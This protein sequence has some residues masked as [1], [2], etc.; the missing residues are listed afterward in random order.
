MHIFVIISIILSIRCRQKVVYLDRIGCRNILVPYFLYFWALKVRKI[1][2]IWMVSEVILWYD[3]LRFIKL[4]DF[5]P[6][7][8]DAWN[9][10]NLYIFKHIFIWVIS[11]LGRI[12]AAKYLSCWK[13]LFLLSRISIFTLISSICQH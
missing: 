11:P 2:L 6:T 5:F 3:Y 12:V 4:L 9:F 1:N 8:S 13:P 7:I 10:V